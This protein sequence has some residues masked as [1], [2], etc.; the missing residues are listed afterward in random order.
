MHEVFCPPHFGFETKAAEGNRR[1]F[2]HRDGRQISLVLK[3]A[4]YQGKKGNFFNSSPSVCLHSC[5]GDLSTK[6]A[7]AIFKK[8]GWEDLI[9]NHVKDSLYKEEEPDELYKQII[10]NINDIENEEY[11][12]IPHIIR[13]EASIELVAAIVTEYNKIMQE[14]AQSI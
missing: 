13:N 10:N 2:V 3:S 4:V 14:A 8:I 7:I 11:F 5:S 6:D 1:L 9:P 12:N